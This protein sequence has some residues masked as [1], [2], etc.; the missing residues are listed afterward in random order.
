MIFNA[1]R[2]VVDAVGDK[3]AEGKSFTA[4][5]VAKDITA[6]VPDFELTPIDVR[7]IVKSLFNHEL[8]SDSGYTRTDCYLSVGD[9]GHARVYHPVGAN[10]LDYPY[11][12]GI[13]G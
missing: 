3:V 12:T 10:P 8:F 7:G 5:E 13:R 4:Y 2:L 9:T 1:Y 11:T 6:L